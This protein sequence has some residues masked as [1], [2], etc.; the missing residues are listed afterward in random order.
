MY[1]SQQERTLCAPWGLHGG[2]A[3]LP[4]GV[5]II[6]QRDEQVQR[7]PTGKIP[8]RRLEAGDRYLTEMG[9]GGGFGPPTERDPLRVLHDVRAGY[10]SLESA[11]RDYKV[12]LR[13]DGR[14]IELD[15]DATRRAREHH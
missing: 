4:N 2:A 9:G 3:A 1:Q 14:A 7:F 8:P 12:V 15:E 11:E 13:R 5:G 10:V 6:G